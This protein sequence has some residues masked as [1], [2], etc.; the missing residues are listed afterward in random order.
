MEASEQK[1]VSNTFTSANGDSFRIALGKGYRQ[2]ETWNTNSSS[3]IATEHTT[4]SINLWTNIIWFLFPLEVQIKLPSNTPPPFIAMRKPRVH[5]KISTHSLKAEFQIIIFDS[6]LWI[7][8]ESACV[9]DCLAMSIYCLFV[10]FSQ[11]PHTHRHTCIQTN[12]LKVS[13]L[14]APNIF[15]QR[16]P[17][18]HFPL[19]LVGKNVHM[20]INLVSILL[21]FIQKRP[22]SLH[23]SASCNF[24]LGTYREVFF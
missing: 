6:V 4:T 21:L 8:F 12:T 13:I 3:Q 9:V 22:G 2:E 17:F 16:N 23:R 10:L 24:P 7:P 19:F 18:C 15:P 14:C 5:T 20:Q 11:F 1:T